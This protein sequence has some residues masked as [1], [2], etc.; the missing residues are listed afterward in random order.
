[1]AVFSVSLT[2]QVKYEE[3]N[4]KLSF[5]NTLSEQV[6]ISVFV[7]SFGLLEVGIMT[8]LSRCPGICTKNLIQDS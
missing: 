5:P 6:Q 3:C 7:Q 4:Y 8:I 1:M 2:E